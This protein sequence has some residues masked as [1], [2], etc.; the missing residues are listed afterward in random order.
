V[1]DIS[2]SGQTVYFEPSDLTELN[3]S[4]IMH[5][6]SLLLEIQKILAE[7]TVH[8]ADHADE[9]DSNLRVL[10]YF[11]FLTAASKFSIQ[12]KCSE[13]VLSEKPVM[14]LCRAHHPVL[15]LM[16]PGTIISNDVVLGEDF[17][18]LIISGANT[19]GK[20]VMLK[21]IGLCA[22]FAMYGLHIPPV[23]TL[24]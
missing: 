12:A 11:D 2:A 4:L 15:Q 17:N 19:G 7:L 1:H 5:E 6:R 22:L 23:P 16:S 8:V 3:N 18:C 9:L 20:T 24:R 13:P 14:K 10:S 21:T